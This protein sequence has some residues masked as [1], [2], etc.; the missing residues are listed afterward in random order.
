MLN[1]K[2]IN[3]NYLLSNAFYSILDFIP[4][5]L[6]IKLQYFVTLKKRLNLKNPKRFTEKIQYYK[7]FYK[8]SKMTICADKYK[9]REY[10]EE[11]GY[12]EYLP[13]LIQV[14]NEFDEII[15]STLPNKYIIKSNNGSGTNIFINDNNTIDKDS[16]RRQTLSWK[17]VNTISIGREW[18][19]KNI[20]SKIII[21]EFLEPNDEFQKKNGLNDYK[22]L[23]FY[24]VPSYIWVDSNRFKNHT[25]NFY[26]LEWNL[27]NIVSDKPNSKIKVDKPKNL[28]QLIEISKSLSSDF[29]FVR[30]DFYILNNRIFIGELT[31]YPWSG[32][33]QFKPDEYD[34]ILGE[35]LDIK[36]MSYESAK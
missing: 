7:L 15:F 32:C 22:V 13:K 12:I 29:P 1:D 31:F 3:Y 23:C 30:V 17:K 35:L 11:K 14:V 20:E 24:G 16:I 21:E 25:R 10:V 5:K 9:M 27:L 26:D 4:D 6:M 19:Y 18:A 2:K 34:F 33:V 28:M 8:N 36:K